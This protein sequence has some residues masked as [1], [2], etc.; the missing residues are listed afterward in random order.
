MTQQVGGKHYEGSYQHWDWALDLRMPP[1]L[2]AATKY[3]DRLGE[4]GPVVEEI[5]KA[6]S[7]LVKWKNWL[8]A[9]DEL[10]RVG[11]SRCDREA[12]ARYDKSRQDKWRH[13]RL[14]KQI[15]Y[16]ADNVFRL[17]EID[18]MVIA[19]KEYRDSYVAK[20]DGQENPFGY[21]RER[22]LV[23]IQSGT[24]VFASED[25]VSQRGFLLPYGV[26]SKVGRVVTVQ[27]DQVLV[28]WFVDKL[29]KPRQAWLPLAAVMVRRGPVPARAVSESRFEKG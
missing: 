25:F 6:V 13:P 3:L 4:K 29:Q 19:M 23:Q 21:E 15:I 26:G 10:P 28:E 14:T 24:E 8:V 16:R 12:T 17:R 22:E 18:E 11:G 20:T 27:D 2:Y 5:D 9:V 1:M 7:Y